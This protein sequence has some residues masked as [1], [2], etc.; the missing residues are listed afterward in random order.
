MPAVS[1]ANQAATEN[2]MA[3]VPVSRPPSP[4]RAKF[5]LK[6]EDYHQVNRK[7]HIPTKHILHMRASDLVSH[8]ISE[9]LSRGE[10]TLF[11]YTSVGSDRRLMWT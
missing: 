4:R 10:A 1:T 9:P 2:P 3:G 6:V 7:N 5:G 11:D 8:C